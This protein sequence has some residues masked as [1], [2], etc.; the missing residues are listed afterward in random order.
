MGAGEGTRKHLLLVFIHII[1]QESHEAVESRITLAVTSA[2]HW[3]A[4]LW[5]VI[6][7]APNQSNYLCQKQDSL[8]ASRATCTI[9]QPMPRL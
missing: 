6:L 8:K 9:R 4:A 2:L 3:F 7:P 1:E 5:A